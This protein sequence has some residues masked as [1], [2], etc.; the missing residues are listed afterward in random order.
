[1]SRRPLPRLSVPEG[2]QFFRLLGDRG[3]LRLLLLME[4]RGEV[5]VGDLA[6]ASGLSYAN[7]SS[8]HLTLLRRAGLVAF[9]REGHRV[10]YRLSS[11]LAAG[12]LR[13]VHEG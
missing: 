12:V 9:R 5:S 6:A 10:Y 2:A 11:P 13:A 4:E 7:V 3:R 8:N 1:M